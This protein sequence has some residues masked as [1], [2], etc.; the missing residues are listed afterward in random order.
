MERR[1]RDVVLAADRLDRFIA[2]RLTKNTNNG[3]GTMLLLFHEAT[4]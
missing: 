3:F 2:F 1:F 4:P